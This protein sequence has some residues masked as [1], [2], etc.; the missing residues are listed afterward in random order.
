MPVC[1][2]FACS[3]GE[4]ALAACPVCFRGAWVK[5]GTSRVPAPAA[6]FRGKFSDVPSSETLS[7]REV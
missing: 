2:G 5:V 4:F 6:A 3:N 7:I 1:P